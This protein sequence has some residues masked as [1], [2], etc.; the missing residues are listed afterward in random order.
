MLVSRNVILS[1]V[2][3]VIYYITI[4]TQDCTYR[5]ES[6]HLYTKNLNI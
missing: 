2:I 3:I 5:R 1:K 6:L 4:L